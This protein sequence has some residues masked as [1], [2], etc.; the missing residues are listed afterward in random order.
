M[1]DLDELLRQASE[2][3]TRGWSFRPIEDRWQRG[4][5][6]WEFS[7]IARA[8][9]PPSADLLDLGTG[10]GELLASVLAAIDPPPRRVY[11]TEGYPPNL[12]VARARLSGA[13][14]EV[15]PTRDDLRIPLP[16]RSV[17]RVI[18]RHEA[19]DA[20]EVRRVLR[21]GGR[22]V[23]QQVG[24]AN[25]V[26]LSD[27]FGTEPAPA[28]NRVD[29]A[30]TLAD[31]VERAGLPVVRTGE[32]TYPERFLDV[33][34]LVFFLRMAPWEVPGFS[35]ERFRPQLA[36]L[37]AEVERTGSLTVTAHRLLVVAERPRLSRAGTA[38]TAGRGRAGRRSSGS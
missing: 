9:L 16:A 28:R 6:S 11:A 35:V 19:F 33:G 38:R 24:G 10:G 32:A 12:P 13:G 22:F 21:P 14:V 25:Y 23:T 4:R 34:A 20:A 29:S 2:L 3:R 30:E 8:D 7:E 15:L 17:D 27:W 31:E 1:A 18:D 26:E 37:H 5:T 36:A